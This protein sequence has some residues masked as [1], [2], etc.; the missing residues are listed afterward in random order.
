MEITGQILEVDNLGLLQGAPRDGAE[1]E[2]PRDLN[3]EELCSLARTEDIKLSLKFIKQL[4][5]ASLED[6]GM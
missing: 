6:N 5:C 2:S 1:K 4:Q 3:L